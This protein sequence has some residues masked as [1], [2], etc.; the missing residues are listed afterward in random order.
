M[1]NFQFNRVKGEIKTRLTGITGT[2]ALIV[3]PCIGTVTDANLMDLVDLTAVLATA[4]DEHAT[5][6]R[7][8]I[9]SGVVV[10]VDNTNDWF[11]ATIGSITW[12]AP[13]ANATPTTRLLICHDSDTATGTDVNVVPLLCYDFVATTDAND[14]VVSPHANGLIRVT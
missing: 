7:K 12:T 5:M 3:V 11:T 8:T 2:N 1:G 10:T 14:I 13:V 6:G 9:N 4:L